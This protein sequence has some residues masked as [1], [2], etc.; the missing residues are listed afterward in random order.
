[1]NIMSRTRPVAATPAWPGRRRERL[2]VGILL[3]CLGGWL[4]IRGF[5]A[6]P[7]H[8]ESQYVA[9]AFLSLDGLIFRDFMSLQ[10]P[11]QA[12]LFAPV[13]WAFPGDT[14]LAMRCA[15]A[16]AASLTL[17]AVYR[18]QRV[19]DVPPYAAVAM[20]GLTMA[21]EV[22]QY[23]AG[24][25]RNDMLPT[26]LVSFGLLAA[27]AG[28]ARPARAPWLLAGLLFGLAASTKLSFAPYLL[29]AALF[30]GWNRRA[31]PSDAPLGFGLGALAGLLPLGLAF[32]L[33]PREFLYG[34]LIF[35]LTAPF[36]W[37]GLNGLGWRMTATAKLSDLLR[38]LI[39]G[40]ALPALLL[41]GWGFFAERRREEGRLAR[42]LL[43][44]LILGGLLG[45]AL[46]TPTHRYYLLPL[47]PPLFVACGMLW[48]SRHHFPARLHRPIVIVLILSVIAGMYNS[49]RSVAAMAVK[50]SPVIALDRQARW[51]GDYLRDRGVRGDIATLSPERMVDSGYPLDPRFATGPF[52]FRSGRLM[53]KARSRDFN[54]ITPA[55]LAEELDRRSPAAILT[56]YQ[57]GTR[58]FRLKP[59]LPLIA[60]ARRRGYRPVD[61]PD[62][63]GL[64]FVHPGAGGSKRDPLPL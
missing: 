44:C 48:R 16:I 5:A 12:W 38:F 54:L 17:L 13:A 26:M 32:V 43:C 62:G 19:L 14:Y 46:P 31:L 7:H 8:D 4:L 1:M 21:C 52:V 58:K 22:F 37:Y 59:D 41:T 27:L 3:A 20:A 64:L 50:G 34:T 6:S 23:A 35:G 55:T 36:D 2:I 24:L 18:A 39:H 10:P 56:G 63:K 47:L 15:T 28:I 30:L 45:A 60:Y 33:A 57:M 51:I 49:V 53:D 29:F 40:P 42:R 9:T 25:I 11:F 61:L